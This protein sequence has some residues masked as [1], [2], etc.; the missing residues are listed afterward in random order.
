MKIW[1]IDRERE[2][3]I[4]E[5]LSLLSFIK[6]EKI[7]FSPFCLRQTDIPMDRH[8]DEW[9]D[10]GQTNILNYRVASLLKN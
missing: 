3:S 6:A 2:Y 10:N 1:S 7:S 9:T 4:H 5:N 8:T